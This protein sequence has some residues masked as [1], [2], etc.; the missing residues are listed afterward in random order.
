MAFTTEIKLDKIEI[1]SNNV[2]FVKLT[3]NVFE[4]DKLIASNIW[5]SPI[6][7]VDDVEKVLEG[8]PYP[9]TEEM[10]NKVK[11]LIELLWTPEVIQ[12]YKT[13]MESTINFQVK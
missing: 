7:P 3:K 4:D 6:T 12:A 10:V 1:E 8:S 13:Q 9:M 5:R 2:L 11:S